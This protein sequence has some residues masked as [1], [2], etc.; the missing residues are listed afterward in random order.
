[1][2]I[3]RSSVLAMAV[4]TSVVLAFAASQTRARAAGAGDPQ[5]IPTGVTITPNAAP[6][7]RF[8]PLNPDVPDDPHFTVDHAVSMAVSPDRKTL[9][10]LTSGYNSENFTSGANK[11]S[12]NPALSQEYVFVY[13]VQYDEPIKRQVLTVPNTLEG[14]TWNPNGLEF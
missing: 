11:G 6:G 7:S 13:D 4:S 8:E 10:V 1:M 5:F 2:K 9:L 12:L 14:I 3:V